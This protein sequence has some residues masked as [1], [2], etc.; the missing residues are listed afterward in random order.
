M[1][2]LF[3]I[4]DEQ[5]PHLFRPCIAGGLVGIN[6]D[7][8]GG[9]RALAEVIEPAV[10]CSLRLACI[11]PPQAVAIINS[12]FDMAPLGLLVHAGG[13]QYRGQRRFNAAL[14]SALHTPEPAGHDAGVI[15]YTRR[16]FK[17]IHFLPFKQYVRRREQGAAGEAEGED[18]EPLVTTFSRNETGLLY[19]TP[20]SVSRAKHKVSDTSC[21]SSSYACP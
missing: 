7:T 9:R 12:N 17:G 1:R 2:E 5:C 15:L 13:F 8:G 20:A 18:A 3:G 14:Y 16:R 10:A 11:Y 6:L 19:T 4:P 21:Q